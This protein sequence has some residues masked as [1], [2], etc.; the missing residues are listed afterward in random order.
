MAATARFLLLLLL[1][2]FAPTANCLPTCPLFFALFTLIFFVFFSFFF[3]VA[4]SS[5]WRHIWLPL[6]PPPTPPIQP[7]VSLLQW[8]LLDSFGTTRFFRPE[9][10]GRL[11]GSNASFLSLS[12]YFLRELIP[13]FCFASSLARFSPPFLSL[14][15]FMG[16]LS[17]IT[18]SFFFYF[19]LVFS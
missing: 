17:D 12:L 11:C 16:L 2:P 7:P 15:L 14:F 1:F 18:Q 19:F 10:V 4:S 8:V 3:F 13:S 6:C 9:M 5:P